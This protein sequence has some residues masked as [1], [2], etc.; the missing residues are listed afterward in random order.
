M[1]A[2]PLHRRTLEQWWC[3]LIAV[4]TCLAFPGSAQTLNLPAR[5]SNAPT[6]SEFVNQISPL[7]LTDREN[8]IYAQVSNGNIP[9]WMRNLVLISTNAVAGGTNYTIGYYVT[10]DYL[11][12]GSDTD[13]FL[14]PMTPLLA[15]KIANALNCSLPTR[16][17]VNHIWSKAPCKLAPSTIP[18]SPSMTTVPVFNQHNS[19][20]RNQRYAVTNTHPLGTLTGGDKKDVVISVRI[21]TNFATSITKPVV[22]YGWHQTSGAPIQPVYNGHEETYADYSHGI[23]LVQMNITINGNPNTITNILVNP[24][25]AALL[26]DET[27]FT[28]NTLPKPRYTI[29]QNGPT[30]TNQPYSQEVYAGAN[31][32]FTTAASGTAP[33]R[34]QWQFAGSNISGATNTALA[35]TNVQPANAG[36]YSV[37]ASN[38]DGTVSS[39]PARLTVNTT[40]NA[41]L[42]ADHFDTNSSANWDLYWGASDGVS[43]YTVSWAF[44]YGT[45]TYTFNGA[46]H[47]IP[48][49]P[50]SAGTTRG[51]R[52][53]VNNNDANGANS[54]VNIYPRNK[55]FSGNFALKCDM[56]IN[57]PG[58]SGGTGTGVAGSTQH[59]LFGINHRGSNVNWHATSA[60]STDGVWFGIAGE[61]G[62]ARDYRAYTG[63]LGG[64]Q[65]EL[66]GSASGLAE[67]NNAAGIY[68]TLLPASRFESPG[69]PGKQ[70]VAMELRQVNNVLSWKIDGTVIA[71][72]TNT[73]SF[74]SGNVMLGLMDVFPSIA[75]PAKDAFILFDNV[76][77]EDLGVAT[78]QPP[79][80]TSPPQNQQCDVGTSISFSV[81]AIGTGPLKYQWSFN[82]VAI[83]GA[84]STSH[85][86]NPVQS[87][88]AGQYT[89]AV[90]NSVG[91][92]SATANLLVV[93]TA[94]R[95]ESVTRELN[96]TLTGSFSG[97]ESESYI[98]EA[99]TD[100]DSWKPIS[101]LPG[102][103]GTF[104]DPEAPSFFFRFY[105]A[106]SGMA[107]VLTDF[108]SFAVGS[109]VVF[110]RPAT[111]GSTAEFLDL[112]AT[113]FA[114]VTN[115]FPAGN[116]SDQVLAARWTFKPLTTNSYLRLTTAN[117][118]NLRNPTVSFTQS[119]S[120][121]IYSDRNIYVAVGLRETATSALIGA[122]GGM[123]NNIEWIGGSTENSYP[124]KGRFVT[125]GQWTTLHFFIPHEPV[126]AFTGDGIL[127]SATGKGVFEHL[128]IVPTTSG[129]H[130]VYIDNVRFVDL[131]D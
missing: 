8:A 49:A 60:T 126:R 16:K 92:A 24:G 39:I 111:S 131:E 68:P 10:P 117:T 84:T 78:N 77:V 100:L 35:R 6:G 106:Y 46:T 11:A 2:K 87:G 104:I 64:I 96:G 53:S 79:S 120:L 37:I 103:N 129:I 62:T 99:S 101:V 38:F 105:R 40:S 98:L 76:R 54:G 50:N 130:S 124:P 123:A 65:T 31:V 114:V 125:A 57:Y 89:V 28:G 90:S 73:T 33:I 67:S 14:C 59:G 61:G 55:S 58:A 82:G 23:R 45:N 56:W 91:Y 122:D 93:S 20:V 63:N 88:H 95:F 5:A 21:Y 108:E 36:L 43:D 113:D 75:A 13:Y 44:N 109:S 110:Q 69:A 48:P 25:L 12:I 97:L 30:I 128:C 127:Q 47:L 51:V 94:S 107:Y 112:S 29:S 42:F 7:S 115:V 52:F 80:I 72:R 83:A 1:V 85:T 102:G 116:D 41:V 18:P 66:L 4:F 27:T 74:T 3:C 121:D 15:Q 118:A 26:S 9:T 70:W 32:T 119:I 17:M 81:A 22:I 34:Y 86:L 71:Q 19:T